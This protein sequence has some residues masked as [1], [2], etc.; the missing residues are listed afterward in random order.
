MLPELIAV[1]SP[2][3]KETYRPTISLPQ[4]DVQSS[5]AR[6]CGAH[7]RQRQSAEDRQ[8]PADQPCEQDN[9][10]GV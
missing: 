2:H 5:G 1:S 3:P 10:E 7:F 9:K 4:I 6:E 8:Q